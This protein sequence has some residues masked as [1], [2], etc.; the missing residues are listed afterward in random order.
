MISHKSL[1]SEGLATGW[2]F[3]VISFV[4]CRRIRSAVGSQRPAQCEGFWHG[5]PAWAAPKF[6]RFAYTER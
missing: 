2:C 3:A 1:R 4:G 6:L 5:L